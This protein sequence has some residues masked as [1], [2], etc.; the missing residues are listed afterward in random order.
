MNSARQNQFS[1][2]DVVLLGVPSDENSSYL[3]GA[4]LAPAAIRTALHSPSANLWSEQGIDLG[5]DPRWHDVGD[6]A[7]SPGV[8]GS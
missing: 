5:N 1:P 3:R 8:A 7:L 2:D 6:L 4:A